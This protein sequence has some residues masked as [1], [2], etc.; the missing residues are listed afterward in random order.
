MDGVPLVSV[1]IPTRN[2]GRQL[3]T[4]L[5][6]LARQSRPADEIIVVDNASSD[7]TAAICAAAGVTHILVDLP[8][9]SATAAAGFDAAAGGI[10]AR[11]DTDSRPPQDWLEH[12]AGI[13]RTSGTFTAV[14]GPGDFYGGNPLVRW[15]GRHLFLAAYFTVVGFLLGHP[16]VYGSNFALTR[17]V[18]AGIRT[19]IV[20][21][22]ADVHD[23]VDISYRLR[24]HMT[25]I[26]EPTLTV[27][28]SARPF[29]SWSSFRRHIAMT[30]VT[31][32]VE[33]RDELPLRRRLERFRWR[34]R[35]GYERDGSG[36]GD[37]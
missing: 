26:Y 23:D 1:V 2:D 36:Q 6:L 11:L 21:D 33:F 14:T 5:A 37:K 13:L 12:V 9:I 24:P 4:C 25:V 22:N 34:Q 30:L 3:R 29:T 7:D 16:P 8:G 32:R 19:A 35:H 18:W 28:V 20:R 10:I 31:F 17:D 27:G 15:S